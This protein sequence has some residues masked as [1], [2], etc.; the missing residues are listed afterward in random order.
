M[1]PRFRRN[2]GDRS[3][4]ASISALFSRLLTDRLA[5]PARRRPIRR[6]LAVRR[7]GA[8]DRPLQPFAVEPVRIL[9]LLLLPLRRLILLRIARRR[10]LLDPELLLEWRRR[11]D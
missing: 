11:Y 9:L 4:S 1:D 3:R 10:G 8:F 5:L 6:S 7:A 2:D